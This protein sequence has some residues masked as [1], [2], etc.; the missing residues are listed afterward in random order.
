M[1]VIVA[2]FSKTGTKTIAAALMDL[3]Y[4]VY[5]FMD[6]F[7][8]HGEDWLKIFRGQGSMDDFKRMYDDVDA[9]VDTPAFLYWD[10]IL[11]A[12][13]DSKIILTTRD[14]D[15][16]YRSMLGQ[17]EEAEKNLLYKVIQILTPTGRKY[18]RFIQQIGILEFGWLKR[19]PFQKLLRNRLTLQR[20]FRRHQTSCLQQAPKDKLLLYNVKDGWEPLCAFLG[21]QVPDKPFPRENVGAVIIAKLMATHPANQRMK[22]ELKI[23]FSALLGV[24]IGAG[25]LLYKN[26]LF[27]RLLFVTRTAVFR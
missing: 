2:G 15:S 9:V 24:G 5:D 4:K 23:A 14:E 6:H 21:K 1:K 26:G 20:G 17:V 13:P 27:S 22:K 3:D 16:W 25:Y 10:T 8:Y 11:E 12:F 7:W 18:F 19:H